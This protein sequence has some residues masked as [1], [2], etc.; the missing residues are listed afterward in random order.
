VNETRRAGRH[1]EDPGITL[2]NRDDGIFLAA[3]MVRH[4]TRRAVQPSPDYDT[5][6]APLAQRQARS[7][8]LT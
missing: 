3:D 6:G 1:E 2:L 8:R 4:F 5:G 7:A